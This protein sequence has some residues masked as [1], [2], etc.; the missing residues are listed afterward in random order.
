MPS[1]NE[2]TG[3]LIPRICLSTGLMALMSEAELEA[4]LLHERYHLRSRDPL[5][6]AEQHQTAAAGS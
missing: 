1:A 2:R 3:S 6:E 5:N 4:V